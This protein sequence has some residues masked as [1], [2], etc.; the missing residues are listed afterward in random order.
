[1]LTLLDANAAQFEQA[2]AEL[3]DGLALGQLLTPLTRYADRG[4][5]YAIDNGAF[6]GFRADAFWSLLERQRSARERCLWVACPDVVGSARRTLELFEHFAVKLH[7]RQ[8]PIALVAQDGQEDLPVPW[9]RIDAV[10][11]GGSTEWKCGPHAAAI[12][13]AAQALGKHTHVGRVNTPD[14]F[15][16]FWDLGVDSIDG[17]GI[18]RYSHMRRRL[19]ADRDAPKLFTGGDAA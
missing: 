2:A 7:A 8:W 14:R 3:G 10:F 17:T 4:G 16:L 5:T 12:I 9:T 1:M 13:R 15:E 19:T 18:S 11:I 6:S